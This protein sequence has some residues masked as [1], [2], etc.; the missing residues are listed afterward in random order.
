MF[1]QA[2]GLSAD[3]A[4]RR[5][6]AMTGNQATHL[7]ASSANASNALQ[8][9]SLLANLASSQGADARANLGIQAGLGAADTEQQNAIR[10]YPMTFLNQNE[11]LL[12]GL[13]PELYAGKTID[14]T[15]S[16]T[17]TNSGTTSEGDP[18]GTFGKAA[19]IAALF[20]TSDRRVKRDVR[21]VGWD[22]KGRR[23]VTF[24]YLWAPLKRVFGVIA[25]EVLKTDPEAVVAGPGGVLVVN[26]ARLI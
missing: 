24:A 23:W 1:T 22:A 11:G 6:A 15:G 13:N 20:A 5:Q 12:S 3:D 19:Q 18:M 17:T 26:Y 8:R 4:A 14:T 7:S 25:Q 16:G 10:Q 21:T 2:T 9:G